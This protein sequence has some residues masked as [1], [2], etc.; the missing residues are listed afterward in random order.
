MRNER[1]G[2][3]LVDQLMAGHGLFV[4]Q[5]RVIAIHRRVPS[6]IPDRSQKCADG[7]E[8]DEQPEQE[9]NDDLELIAEGRRE[10]SG[11]LLRRRLTSSVPGAKAGAACSHLLSSPL[12]LARSWSVWL[13]RSSAPQAVDAVFDALW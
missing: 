10:C 9:A 6:S 4:D 7:D 3:Q 5:A 2:C 1:G 8:I 13:F 12:S 11:S